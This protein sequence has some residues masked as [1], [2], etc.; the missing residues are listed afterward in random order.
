MWRKPNVFISHITEE[1][2]A[3]QFIQDNLLRDFAQSVD[4]FVSSDF[5]S[6]PLGN[7]WQRH[8]QDALMQADLML[9]LCSPTS[10]V[11]PWIAF[12]AGAGWSRGIPVIPICHAGMTPGKVPRPI[13]MLQG[14]LASEDRDWLKVYSRIAEAFAYQVPSV[15]FAAIAKRFGSALTRE[16][17]HDSS[18][19]DTANSSSRGAQLHAVGAGRATATADVSALVG[20]QVAITARD[21]TDAPVCDVAL[22][23]VAANGTYL[24]ATT[25]VEGRAQIIVV[26]NQRYTMFCAHEEFPAVIEIWDELPASISVRLSERGTDGSIICPSGTGYIPGLQGRL[27]PILDSLGRRY[28]YGDNIAIEGGETQPVEFVVGEPLSVEDAQGIT[29]QIVIRDIIGASSLIEFKR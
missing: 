13:G 24:S 12:E 25:D 6:L 11:R 20:R 18:Q 4:V 27:N 9:V 22:L 17:T 1:A 3:A 23:F 15:S 2:D 8:V 29:M 26:K 21:D 5:H 10:V 19:S 28:L 16:N 14:C 7:D